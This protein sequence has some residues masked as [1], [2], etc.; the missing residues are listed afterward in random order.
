MHRKTQLGLL[1]GWPTG[2]GASLMRVL[3]EKWS[4]G[5]YGGALTITLKLGEQD[6][7][8][9][10][11]T[12][13]GG[14]VRFHPLGAMEPGPYIFGDAAYQRV[15]FGGLLVDEKILEENNNA[16]SPT[17]GAGYLLIGDRWWL[18]VGAGWGPK[19]VFRKRSTGIF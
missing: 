15:V 14:R 16:F 19:H 13:I 17:A 1:L 4:A 5:L 7:A 18:D 3:D 2:G 12:R 6:L 10:N 8:N 9:F 11:L